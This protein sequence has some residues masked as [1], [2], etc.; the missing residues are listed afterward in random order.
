MGTKLKVAADTATCLEYDD[1]TLARK[2]IGP[3]CTACA[4][5]PRLRLLR[6]TGLAQRMD[7]LVGTASGTATASVAPEHGSNIVDVLAV[8]QLADGLEVAVAAADEINMLDSV[9]VKIDVDL[10]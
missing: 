7:K 5:N 3:T 10:S 1:G 9:A 2:C 4:Q 6:L 8:D